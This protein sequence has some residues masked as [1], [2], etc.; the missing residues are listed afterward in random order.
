[1]TVNERRGEGSRKLEHWAK[2]KLKWPCF[3]VAL[4]GWLGRREI[5]ESE[6]REYTLLEPVYLREQFVATYVRRDKER[7]KYSL[8]NTGTQSR[9][10]EPRNRG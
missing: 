3:G 8:V 9:R 2:K 10:T 6:R 7:G 5:S 4:V 1:M